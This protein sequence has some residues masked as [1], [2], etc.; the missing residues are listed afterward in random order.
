MSL[1]LDADFVAGRVGDVGGGPGLAL[2]GD[3]PE[4]A[5][6]ADAED[7]F[8]FAKGACGGVVEGVVLERARRVQQEAE[9]RKARLKAGEIVDGE[10]EFDLGALH[11]KSIRRRR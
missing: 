5:V 10:L 3:G 7:L 8:G 1:R 9:A 2:V 11:S 4:V 6:L